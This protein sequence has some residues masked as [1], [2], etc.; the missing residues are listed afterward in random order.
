MKQLLN[1]ILDA[2]FFPKPNDHLLR[3]H[4]N[5]QYGNGLILIPVPNHSNEQ[6]I[7]KI[8]R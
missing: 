2:L 6:G 1:S 5:G 4:T 8:N 7:N 3:D